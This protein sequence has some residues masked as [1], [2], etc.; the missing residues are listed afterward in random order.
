M[1]DEVG[2]KKVVRRI[3][4]GPLISSLVGQRPITQ[5]FSLLVLAHGP[6]APFLFFRQTLSHHGCEKSG[7]LIP[8]HGGTQPL[9]KSAAGVEAEELLGAGNIGQ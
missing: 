5:G 7:V 2:R 3:A 8:F 6:T 4:A 1:R 9:F